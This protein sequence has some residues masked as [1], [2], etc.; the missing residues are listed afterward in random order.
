M[1]KGETAASGVVGSV[2]GFMLFMILVT[3]SYAGGSWR[4][5]WSDEFEEDGRPNPENWDYDLGAGGWGN[6][7]LQRYTDDLL[8]ARVEDGRL[9]IEVHQEL[10]GRTPSYT[11]ARLVTRGKRSFQYGKFEIRAK[12]PSETGTW[13]AIWMLAENPQFSDVFWP[14]NGE[15]DILE[16]VGY[17]EDPLFLAKVGRDDLE[18]IHSTLHTR[19]L[20]HIATPGREMSGKRHLA[21]ATQQFHTYSLIWTA[22]EMIFAVDGVEHYRARKAIDAGMSV[23]NPPAPED[24]WR[25]WPFDQEF[26]LILNVA[27]GGSWGGHFNTTLY[28]DSPY[29]TSGVNHD[30]VWPQVMEV[31]Y[32]RVYEWVEEPQNWNGYEV[33]EMGFADTGDWLGH[34]YTGYSPWY[35]STSLQSWIY[36]PI[37]TATGADAAGSW[38]WLIKQ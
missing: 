28:P 17:E 35:Y 22:E 1:R 27:I 10:G 15:I 18:N 37:S 19:E 9:R 5:V 14:D 32:V 23:R 33:D 6:N 34:V 31:E 38:I 12:L 30:G 11:S 36:M 8:N 13:S 25:W 21:T 2:C 26:H 24:V 16:H 4:L 7:E 3:A 29:G 20:N